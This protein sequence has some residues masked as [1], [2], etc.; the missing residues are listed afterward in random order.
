MAGKVLDINV[1]SPLNLH[2]DLTGK[3]PVIG[4]YS[5]NLPFTVWGM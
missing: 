2:S 3:N 1:C 4:H 5:Y